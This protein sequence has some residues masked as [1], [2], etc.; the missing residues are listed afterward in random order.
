MTSQAS[1]SP[2]AGAE[3]NAQSH[4]LE[5]QYQ[6][7]MTPCAIKHFASQGHKSQS[8]CCGLLHTTAPNPLHHPPPAYIGCYAADR[9]QLFARSSSSAPRR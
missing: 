7:I 8:C 2:S 1:Q 4:S 9:D 6:L 3:S 5:S